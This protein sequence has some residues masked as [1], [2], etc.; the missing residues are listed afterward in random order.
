MKPHD[1]ILIVSS[2]NDYGSTDSVH[3]CRWCRTARH[4]YDFNGQTGAAP[5]HH[6]QWFGVAEDAG[7]TRG[8]MN[9]EAALD[10][11]GG[12]Q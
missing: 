5:V 12:K 10:A 7:C 8:D 6:E 11:L 3:W 9:E 2:S 4:D 1:W